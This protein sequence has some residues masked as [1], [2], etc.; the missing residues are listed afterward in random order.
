MRR[1]KRQRE[2][3]AAEAAHNAAVIAALREIV[4]IGNRMVDKIHK[5]W[6]EAPE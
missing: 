1:R 3:G 5:Q 6:P 2:R 4:E